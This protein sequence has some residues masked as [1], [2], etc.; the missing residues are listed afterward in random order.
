MATDSTN[1]PQGEAHLDAGT[2]MTGSELDLTAVQ[3]AEAEPANWVDLPQGNV[4]ILLPVQPGQTVRLP[5]DSASGLLAK[6][7]PEGNLAIVVDGRTIILQGFIKANDQ[8]P[9]KIVANDGDTLDVADLIAAT[10]P[11]L[12]IQTAAGPAT[13]GQGEGA[14]GSGI[15]V[16]F[17]AGPGLG[18]LNALGVLDPTALQYRLIT[19]ERLDPFEEEEEE[20]GDTDFNSPPDIDLDPN[21]PETD[22][23]TAVV[24]DEG[25]TDGEMD[26]VGVPS[27][28]TDSATFI[29]ALVVS[30]PDVG[31]VL[32][33]KMINP[34]TLPAWTFSGGDLVTWTLSPDGQTLTGTAGGDPAI[35]ISLSPLVGNSATYTVT[36]HQ[37]LDHPIENVEDEL[38]FTVPVRVTDSAGA[39]D[40]AILTVQVEDDSPEVHLTTSGGIS[41]R[42]DETL[43]GVGDH[44]DNFGTRDE[45]DEIGVNPALIIPAF[46]TVIGAASAQASALF[47]YQPGADG[48]LSHLY[49]LT[50]TDG[51]ATG[52]TD[53]ATGLPIVLEDDG[54]GLILGKTV[55]GGAVVFALTIDGASGEIS[56]AQYRAIRH[57]DTTSHDDI[58]SML[59]GKLSATLTVTDKDHD[60]ASQSVDIS[61]AITFD[62]DGPS[63]NADADSVTEDGPT[64]ASGNVITGVDGVLDIDENVEDGVIDVLGADGFGGITWADPDEVGGTDTNNS[65][66]G[67]CGTLTVDGNGNYKYE[68]DNTNS[69]V[70][71]LNTGDKLT[72]TFNYT[73]EDGDGDTA[74]STLTITINGHTDTPPPVAADVTAKLDEDGIPVIGNNDS[75]PGDDVTGKPDEHI[76]HDNL[77]IDWNG[78]PGDITVAAGDWSALKSI[79][80]S[81]IV[82]VV[83]GGGH[84]LQGYDADDVAGGVP[85]DGATPIFQVD[86]INSTTGEYQ[87]TLFKPLLHP[88]SNGDSV[89]DATDDGSA[90]FEDNLIIPVNVTLTSAGGVDTAVLNID[91]DDDSPKT[92]VVAT[93]IAPIVLDESRPVGSDTDGGAPAG[94]ETI[95]VNLGATSFAPVD[96]GADGAGSVSYALDLNGVDVPSGLYALEGSDTS[97]GDGDGIGQGG[98]IVLNQDGNVIT[99]SFGGTDYF[100][101]SADPS[102]GDVTFTQ[103]NNIWHGNAGSNDDAAILNLSSADVLKLVQKVEDADGDAATAS[104]NLGQGVFQIQ[105]D[106]PVANLLTEATTN[107]GVDTNLLITLDISG[108]M[109]DSSGLA[110]LNKFEAAI[111]A[112]K[113]LIEQYDALGDVKVRIVTFSSSATEQGSVWMTPDEARTFLNALEDADGNTNYDAALTAAMNAF[114]DD[115]KIEGAQNVAYFLSDGNPNRPSGDIGID[116]AEEA[117]WIEFLKANDINSFALGFGK[118]GDVDQIEIDPIAY[119]GVTEANTD[120][121]VITDL[122]LLTAALVSTVSPPVTGNVKTDGGNSIGTDTPGIVSQIKFD[123]TTFSYDGT[124]IVQ[125]GTVILF[126]F[127]GGV[128]TFSTPNGTLQINMNTGAYV[129]ALLTSDAANDQFEYTLTDADGDSATNTLT[130]TATV[131]DVAPIVRD[132]YVFTNVNGAGASVV[133][134]QSAFLWNDSDANGDTIT[135]GA[136]SNIADLASVTPGVGDVTITDDNS[137]GGTFAYTGTA[138]GKPDTGD[139]FV[140]RGQADETTLDGSGLDNIL[141]GRDGENDTLKGYEGNDVLL[142]GS[143][144][145]SLDGGAGRDWLVGGD[146]NDTL[147]GGAGND[148][149]EGGNGTDLLD[150]SDVGSGF[151]FALAAGGSGTA[152]VSG[153]DVYSGIEGVVGGSGADTITG[154]GANDVLLG[155]DGSDT[156]NGDAGDDLLLGG[157]G[158]DALNGGDGADTLDGGA[159]DDVYHGGKGADTFITSSGHDT[160]VYKAVADLDAGDFVI[161]FDANSSGGHDTVDLD[162]LFDELNVADG[163]RAGRVIVVDTGPDAEVRIDLDG[164]NIHE[165]TI[166]T[167]VG[168]S[169][170]A[171]VNIGNGA[172]DDIRLGTL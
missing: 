109:D 45:N 132:D 106:G 10:D 117:A 35:T 36:L 162:A 8:S 153:T 6:I 85:N 21:D 83:G 79:D 94:L 64:I 155:G 119:D 69:E 42:V 145:D 105:D 138:N 34:G 73:I 50:V 102:N 67:L 30:D 17:N 97:D 54:T 158:G 93:G 28:D 55:P 103:I 41:L 37:P 78:L 29:G 111:A 154:N 2:D 169:N 66:Q 126:T 140:D 62:D 77:V 38:S 92:T 82:A 141:V 134:P 101:I 123:G 148:L 130:V 76:W 72:E 53:T 44:P 99:G 170:A 4:V 7:G 150:F 171:I 164:D 46:G 159:D 24:S 115:G 22:D 98:Q 15:F 39:F 74:S 16:P 118:A 165:T 125:S 70:A 168:V 14:D 113:E 48:E 59:A 107:S 167:L 1:L 49:T 68:L 128:L 147:R 47:D 110:N 61:G 88:D 43:G 136:I 160:I 163:D 139:V 137:N 60:Q 151:T 18:G 114:S 91:V 71:A 81:P 172:N 112:I 5:T 23:R 3:L 120:G 100:T 96:Y 121:V 80:G 32:T 95:T 84:I 133:V 51:G 52:L 56:M 58:Q 161:G 166:L 40:T 89:D 12:D 19:D 9:V 122:N 144:D 90:L 57:D 129:Y 65:I 104:V 27:D 124:S 26:D 31:D 127:V 87:V 108:S 25:L 63:A 75:A 149:I 157:E 86:I 143:G 33:V 142:A 13:G 146:G 11:S 135:F 131:A 156:L 152:N 116:A 20:E